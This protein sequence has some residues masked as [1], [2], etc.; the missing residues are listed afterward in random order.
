MLLEECG[1]VCYD[2][3]SD[4]I[5][6]VIEPN[7]SLPIVAVKN[8][9]L[10]KMKFREAVFFPNFW[11]LDMTCSA[12][13]IRQDFCVLNRQNN[14]SETS[15]AV[16]TALGLDFLSESVNAKVSFPVTWKIMED[17]VNSGQKKK[18]LQCVT[19]GAD[20]KLHQ[21]V[22]FKDSNHTGPVGM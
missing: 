13:R 2:Q 22:Y 1:Y 17:G 5:K 14:A 15:T 21:T 16:N 8:V 11:N 20:G 19:Y 3:P 4:V 6:E 10:P 9:V 7:Q 12:T 18:N